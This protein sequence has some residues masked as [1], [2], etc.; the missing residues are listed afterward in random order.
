MRLAGID[1]SCNPSRRK[2]ITVAS[3]RL[4]GTRLVLDVVDELPTLAGFEAWLQ[5]RG[6]WLAGFD[7]PFGL[8][9]E[10]VD[11]NALGASAA[12]VI[13]TVRAR[14]PSRMAWRAFI[15]AWGNARPH[16]ARLLH[17][18]TDLASPAASTSPMQTRYV[19]VGLMYYE[20]VARLIAA[21]VSL[22]GLAHDGDPERIALEAY[23]R[24]LAHA[25]IARRSYKNDAGDDRRAAREAIVA[26]L[27]AGA[28][29]IGFALDCAAPLRAS[30]VADA[31]GDR[32]DAVLCLAQAAI[33]SR[34]VRYG[35][36]GDVDPVEGWIAAD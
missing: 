14:C 9:R 24:R 15:D 18:R 11:A 22:P 34:R 23:P 33:A 25:L 5:Q 26:G 36:P 19:P 29:G 6:P 7:F 2:P 12:E 3:G 21:G 27:E 10:F 35:L 28:G 8:P 30:L 4:D 20:G 13:A 17:R 16:G 1:F 31:S 32:L